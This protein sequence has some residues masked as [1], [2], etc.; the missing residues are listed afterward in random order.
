MVMFHFHLD[1]IFIAISKPDCFDLSDEFQC[2]KIEPGPSY[3]VLSLLYLAVFNLSTLK[4]KIYHLS[5]QRYISPPPINSTDKIIIDV[6]AD[7]M[8]ILDINEI[9][10]IF[11]VLFQLVSNFS[12][13]LRLTDQKWLQ[14]QFFLHLTWQDS[15]LKFYNL[16]DDTGLNALSPQVQNS[17]HHQC[18]HQCHRR[19]RFCGSRCS[20]LRTLKTSRSPL[21]MRKL[22]S[23]SRSKA[24]SPFQR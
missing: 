11:Q 15:R 3:Q 2:R 7:I 16:K 21:Q 14:V 17:C 22:P 20:P 13:S 6:S 19:R 24:N 12:Q 5:L 1:H 18:Y 8:S 23:L 9:S 4:Q 10:S